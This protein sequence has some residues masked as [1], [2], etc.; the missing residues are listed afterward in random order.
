MAGPS[1]TCWAECAGSVTHEAT[2]I[3]VIDEPVIEDG[4][5]VSVGVTNHPHHAV[6]RDRGEDRRQPLEGQ[7]ADRL[8]HGPQMT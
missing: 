8:K 5:I 1:G 3:A 6:L 4:R 2:R 7:A